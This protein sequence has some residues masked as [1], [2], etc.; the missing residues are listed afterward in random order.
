MGV[1][2]FIDLRAERLRK[3]QSDFLARLVHDFRS[4]LST[5]LAGI[6]LVRKQGLNGK[7]LS[8]NLDRIERATR[9]LLFLIEG[10]LATEGA[11]S[12]KLQL[13]EADVQVAEVAQDVAELL[14]PRAEE[15]GID[16][17]VEV[18]S[19]LQVKTDRLL[20]GQVLQNL[21]DNALKYTDSGE[22]VLRAGEEEGGVRITVEDTGRGIPSEFLSVIFDIYRRTEHTSA[23]R[24]VGLA[25]VKAVVTALGG[26]V[27]AESRESQG[28]RFIVWLPGRIPSHGE[29]KPQ[30][31][32]DSHD[33]VPQVM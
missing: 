18:A 24:G 11:L 30:M 29:A 9:R 14:R 3:R 31:L 13:R 23:G 22:V 25:V 26:E 6:G 32:P 7:G 19:S 5:I 21:L 17:R 15:Q 4:P 12:G 28:S 20:L 1:E 33:S 2:C 10:Q 27:K 16:L 8:K